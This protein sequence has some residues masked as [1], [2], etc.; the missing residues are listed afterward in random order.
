VGVVGAIVP[1]N[2]PLQMLT[3]KL[4]PALA[5]GCT[6]VLK[7]AEQTPVTAYEFARLIED[8]GIPPGVVNIV[9]GFGGSVGKHLVSH[10]GVHKIS[11]TGDHRTAQDIMRGAAGNLKKLTFECGGKAPHIIF[12]DANLEQAI[13]AAAYNAF[14]LTGQSCALGS[15]LLVHRS[16]HDTVLDEITRR[17]GRIRVGMPADPGTQMGPQAHDA[18]LR[19][20]LSY[21]EIAKGEGARLVTGGTRLKDNGLGSGFF[22]APTVF[23]DVKP[24]M[25][26]AQEEIFGPVVTVIPFDDEQEAL[27]IANGVE[28]GLTAVIWTQD[29]GLAHRIASSIEAG[30]VWVNTYRYVR[31]AIPYG[32]FKISGTGRENGV[33]GMDAFLQTRATVINLSG[34]YPDPYGQ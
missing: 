20:T 18:Q 24:R 12:E 15:R 28:Y 6:V 9:S 7:S 22:V 11:F 5:A 4:A 34:K 25:R 29:V 17:A 32:G 1:W 14:A 26:V 23:A 27:E 21:M 2:V 13:N 33:E 3:W 8:I 31:W 19:K 10:P 16:V 30:T